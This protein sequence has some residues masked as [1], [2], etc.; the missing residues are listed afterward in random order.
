MPLTA[1]TLATLFVL[2]FYIFVSVD[3]FFALLRCVILN[4]AVQGEQRGK[5]L[6]QQRFDGSVLIRRSTAV[7]IYVRD[8]SQ[9]MQSKPI[10]S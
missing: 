4:H 2:L 5:V 10:C 9:G 6:R 7:L 1:A 8:L 3:A